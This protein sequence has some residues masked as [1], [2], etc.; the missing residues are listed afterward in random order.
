MTHAINYIIRELVD[1][2]FDD[3]DKHFGPL[4]VYKNSIS[5]W[6]KYLQM[7][8]SNERVVSIVEK[9]NQAIGIATL[10][11]KSD[12]PAFR[13]HKIPEINDLL[14]AKEHRKLGYG[15]A[16]IA[17]LEIIA[18]TAG[19]KTIGIGVGLYKDYGNAQRLY[20]KLGYIPDGNGVSYK[21]HLVV[22]GNKYPVD[23]EL[24]LWLTKKL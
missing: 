24:I 5:K 13:N 4:T 14:I 10:K 2:D 6:Q 15:T 8:N 1:D 3:L 21:E 22:P 18:K 16:L 7:Q 12:Y 17:S 20:F 23:D 9:D 19:Y 11:F